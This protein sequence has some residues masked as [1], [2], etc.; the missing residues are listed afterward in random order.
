[1]GG[2]YALGQCNRKDNTGGGFA[3][4]FSVVTQHCHSEVALPG[5]GIWFAARWGG[6][7]ASRVTFRWAKWSKLMIRFII[8]QSNEK[9]YSQALSIQ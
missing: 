1:M 5:Q 6:C 4:T 3:E 2:M 7:G 9:Q 8:K